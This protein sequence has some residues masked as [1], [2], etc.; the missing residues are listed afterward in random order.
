MN[1]PPGIVVDG[2]GPDREGSALQPLGYP[3]FDD[4]LAG[5]PQPPGLRIE[6]IDHPGRKIHI[7]APVLQAGP[8]RFRPIDVIADILA[9]V[10]PGIEFFRCDYGSSLVAF[11]SL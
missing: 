8:P 1:A 6:R 11:R 10:E 5:H 9:T 3:D 7:H 4:R 2:T